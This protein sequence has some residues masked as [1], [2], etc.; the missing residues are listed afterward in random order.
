[1]ECFSIC[2]ENNNGKEIEFEKMVDST[3]RN[4]AVTYGGS[5]GNLCPNGYN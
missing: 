1:M 3:I 4:F 2:V 5:N